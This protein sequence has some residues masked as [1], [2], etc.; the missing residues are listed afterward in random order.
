LVSLFLRASFSVSFS[1][2]VPI[3]DTRPPRNHCLSTFVGKKADRYIHHHREHQ[4]PPPVKAAWWER[5]GKQGGHRRRISSP[6]SN[7]PWTRHFRRT[8][9]SMLV[10]III[11]IPWKALTTATRL[12]VKEIGNVQSGRF[13]DGQDYTDNDVCVKE[14]AG[15]HLNNI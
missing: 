8:S 6:L 4:P 11:T 12:G 15:G 13:F 7:A 5:K 1:F 14:E 2:P 9:T 3:R 10:S